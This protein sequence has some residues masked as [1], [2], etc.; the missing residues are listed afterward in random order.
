MAYHNNPRIVTD[1]LVLCLDANAKRSYSGSGSTWSDLTSNQYSGA[2]SGAT[3]NSSGYF[4]FD[5]TDDK[6]DLNV[7][8]VNGLTNYSISFWVNLDVWT[9][10]GST[11]YQIYAEESGIWIANYIDK[12]GI[13]FHNG[14]V[15]MDNNGGHND[16]ML[17]TVPASDKIN[18]W[19]NVT[20]TYSGSTSST[21]A[22]ITGY[23]NGSQNFQVTTSYGSG[24]N[25]QLSSSSTT[26]LRGG[27]GYRRYYTT[28]YFN[29]KIANMSMY[30]KT[31][32][33]AEVSENYNAH[34]SRF[35]L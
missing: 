15:W 11:Q 32:S 13:D 4:D 2:I 17:I 33:A 18:T 28:N 3:Y 6:V 34:K 30:N 25:S 24:S 26:S 9:S 14:T 19:L 7:R 23:L 1:G 5:G 29:G 35:G 16:G 27:I 20:V 8:T 22:T 10:S 21:S 31:L 12:I